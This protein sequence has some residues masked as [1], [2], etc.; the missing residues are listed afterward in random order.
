MKHKQYRIWGLFLALVIV[1]A[2]SPAFG[3]VSSAGATAS[4]PAGEWEAL[5]AGASIWYTLHYASGR[6][7]IELRLRVTPEGSATLAV[8]TPDQMQRLAEGQCVEPVGRA[9]SDPLAPG[10]LVWSGSF[11][12]A[13]DYSVVVERAANQTGT[14]YYLLEVSGSGA[15]LTKTTPTPTP[16]PVVRSQPKAATASR[17]TG[18]IVF[19]TTYGGP[20]YT[21]NTDGTGLRRITNGI[22]PVWS[23]DGSQIAFVRW[24][25]PRGVWVI[26]ADGSGERRVFDWT[27]A[28]HPSWSPDG[29]QIVF[30]RQHGTLSRGGGSPGFGIQ[31]RP[32]AG[33]GPGGPSGAQTSAWRLGV[34]NPND[35]TFWEPLP[36]A[37]LSQTPDWSP[38]GDQI[39]FNG[40]YGLQVQSADG[41]ES[42]KL[43]TDWTDTTPAWS[44]DG[45]KVAFIR[46][47]HDHWEIW[48]VDADGRNARR[49]TNTPALPDGTAGSSVS[50][51]W[52]PDGQYI[53]F[54]TNQTGRWEIWV[55]GADGSKPGPLFDTEL[56]S[57]TLE[58]AFAGERALDWT[59]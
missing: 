28:R 47:Q 45:K 38:A 15:S 59:Q 56:S 12:A 35:G 2:F 24:E 23:P 1:V 16:T 14:S 7:Q 30:T 39:V 26:N 31:R 33:G 5:N 21:I 42:Y 8:W 17:L 34:V 57:L 9:S 20:F 36:N 32:P 10:T 19:Q 29:T 55:M 37:D 54:L 11:P 58:Y 3:L 53:A 52:S 40:M 18:K 46:R 6:S 22:D 25:E 48:V 4:G 44:P 50:P 41:K 27:E 43:T 51:A 49:L 13:G